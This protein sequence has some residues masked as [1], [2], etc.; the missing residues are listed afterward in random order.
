MARR[1]RQRQEN[2]EQLTYQGRI[3]SDPDT[4]LREAESGEETP[5]QLQRKVDELKQELATLASMESVKAKV[6]NQ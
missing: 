2:I 3:Y 4:M 5:Q 6:L 1:E